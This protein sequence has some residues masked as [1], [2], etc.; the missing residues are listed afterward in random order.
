MAG[1]QGSG[2][3]CCSEGGGTIAG[4]ECPCSR[5]RRTCQ[6]GSSSGLRSSPRS[7]QG[8]GPELHGVARLDPVDRKVG[9]VRVLESL[10]QHGPS[11]G[12]SPRI[13]PRARVAVEVDVDVAGGE[14]ERSALRG[15]EV[16]PAASGSPGTG[17][18]ASRFGFSLLPLFLLPCR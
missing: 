14:S 11:L 6:A 5:A 10:G 7:L 18:A 2:S 4:P 12:M 3:P 17:Q 16:S 13:A 8:S 9:Q 15:G 1:E